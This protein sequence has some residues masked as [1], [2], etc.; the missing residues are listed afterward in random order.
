ML[1]FRADKGSDGFSIHGFG[2][3]TDILALES[4]P[5]GS[6]RSNHDSDSGNDMAIMYGI[7]T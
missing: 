7:S 2:D 3:A 5:T 4:P 6:V 1:G